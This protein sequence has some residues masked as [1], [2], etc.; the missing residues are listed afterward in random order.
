M[1]SKKAFGI[2]F[3]RGYMTVHL[4]QVGVPNEKFI[5]PFAKLFSPTWMYQC[6]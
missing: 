4:C 2:S 3:G 5:M 1:L 6:K